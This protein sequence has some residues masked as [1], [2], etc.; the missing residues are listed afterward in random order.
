[1]ILPQLSIFILQG[2]R[3]NCPNILEGRMRPMGCK[4]CGPQIVR[5]TREVKSQVHLLPSS[6][7]WNG[8]EHAWIQKNLW[9]RRGKHDLC[10][11]L[12]PGLTEQT[13]CSLMSAVTFRAVSSESRDLWLNRWLTIHSVMKPFFKVRC[14]AK[15]ILLKFCPFS[16]GNLAWSK[17]KDSYF[18]GIY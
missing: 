15:H 3:L 2:S 9:K 10:N 12:S 14:R 6:G 8:E 5:E 16:P 11:I 4:N 18:Q 13:R 17:C 1:M 7:I